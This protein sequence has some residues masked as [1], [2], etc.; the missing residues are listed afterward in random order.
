[1]KVTEIGSALQN[2]Q[3][4]PLCSEERVPWGSS[5]RQSN[6]TRARLGAK[7]TR[8][9]TH[10]HTHTYAVTHTDTHTDGKA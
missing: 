2:A 5:S 3:N 10:T 4:E 9:C 7:G 1:M 6:T 8:V